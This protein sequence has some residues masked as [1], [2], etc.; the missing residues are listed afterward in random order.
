VNKYVRAAIAAA[1]VL[2][3]AVVGYNMLPRTGGPGGPQTAAPTI[4]QT[5]SP[6]PAPLAVG[7]FISHSAATQLDATG[8]GSNV[9]GTMTVSDEGGRFTVDLACART[10]DSGLIVIGG[11]VTDSTN[12]IAPVGSHVAIILQRASPV[13]AGFYFEEPQASCPA[14]LET[15]PD[16]GDPAR[17]P[18]ALEPIEGT[19]ELRP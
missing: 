6:S 7:S 9:T 1:A 3:V 18:S 12:D 16:L 4:Q 14:F 5:P 15:I 13:K 10:T 8:D 2:V 19:M 17:D 11:E